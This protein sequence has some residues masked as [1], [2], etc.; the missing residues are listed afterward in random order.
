MTEDT[1][2]PVHDHPGLPLFR[3]IARYAGAILVLVAA[4]TVASALRLFDLHTGELRLPVDS[5]LGALSTRTPADR[6]FS[7][8]VQKRYGLGDSIIVMV[9]AP[10]VFSPDALARIASLSERL[11]THDDVHA[12]LSI[13]TVGLPRTSGGDLVVRRLTQEDLGDP[14]ALAALRTLASENPLV[15]GQLV[16][17]PLDAAALVVQLEPPSEREATPQELVAWVREQAGSAAAPG[18]AVRT[19]GAMVVRAALAS[20]IADQLRWGVPA[21]ALVLA[22]ALGVAFRSVYAVVLPVAAIAI[23]LIVTFAIVCTLD[24]PLNLV[25]S[26]APPLLVTMGLAYGAHVLTAFEEV[27]REHPGADPELRAYLLL[28]EIAGPV[29]LTGATTAISLLAL[30]LNDLPAIREFA[31]I[32]ALGVT[33]TVVLVLTFLPAALKFWP[34]GPARGDLPGEHIFARLSLGL[35]AWDLRHRRRILGAATGLGILAAG[36]AFLIRPGEA[37]VG[38]FHPDAPVRQDYEAVGQRLGGVSPLLIE[39]DSGHDEGIVRADVLIALEKLQQWLAAQPEVGSVTGL[40]DQLR[41]LDTVIGRNAKTLPTDPVLVQQ[42]LFFGDGPNLRGVINPSHGATLVSARLRADD[43][44]EIAGLLDRLEPQLDSL[45][46]GLTARVTG[47]AADLAHSVESATQGQLASVA[48]SLALVF[49][50]L[51][52]QFLSFRV[53]LLAS[54]PT[55]LQTALYFGALGISGVRLNATTGLVECLVLGLAVDDT[56]H[57]LA[58]FDVAARRT[59]SETRAAVAALAAVIRPATLTKGL[60]A[61]GFLMLVGGP[62]QNQAAFGWLAAF[63]LVAAWLVDA[64]VVPAFMGGMRVVTI[65]D[66]LRLDL[67]RDVQRTIPI[68]AGLSARQARVF[69]LMANLEDLPA[70]A[71]IFTEGDSAGQG[72]RGDPAGDACIIV[73]GRCRVWTMRNGEVVVIREVGRGAVLGEAGYFGQKRTATVDTL[74]PCRILRIDD[75]DQE[76]ICKRYPAIAARVFLNLN[77]LQAERRA[78]N[79]GHV[80]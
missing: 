61:L 73:E 66:S 78:Q 18:F 20:T 53:G 23:A 55:V 75:A 3:L 74:T 10:D 15:R 63:T 64:V 50:C 57:Y 29:L 25:T 34:R 76:R 71:R 68:F 51:S 43:S 5:S 9:E 27:R 35:G 38:V 62:L 42:L 52:L 48:L 31:L 46:P 16:S 32:A 1:A 12:V 49:A 72:T 45:P 14:A 22:I 41:V 13:T 70:G 4:V 8:S 11:A 58:R 2:A 36:A 24:R 39:I 7:E 80:G 33:V 47:E 30:L 44:A 67:G 69:A 17:V 37:F 6:A 21:V 54:L 65:W 28:S 77:R 26:L 59:G 19:T 79:H 56:I 40:V 60:L